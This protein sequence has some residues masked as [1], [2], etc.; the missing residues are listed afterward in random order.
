[1]LPTEAIEGLGDV[2]RIKLC[3]N[4][5]FVGTSTRTIQCSFITSYNMNFLLL[6]LPC[7]HTE[8]SSA[9]TSAFQHDLQSWSGSLYSSPED[10][11]FYSPIVI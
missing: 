3:A 5:V 2:S 7:D 8:E 9:L 11:L 10:E 6:S 4:V 1:M